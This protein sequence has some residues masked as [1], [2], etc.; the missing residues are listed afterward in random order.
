MPAVGAGAGSTYGG[1]TGGGTAAAI[2]GGAGSG[3]AG[4]VLGAQAVTSVKADPN[5]IGLANLTITLSLV[6]KRG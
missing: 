6:G 4:G 3:G 5:M 1:A 2:G